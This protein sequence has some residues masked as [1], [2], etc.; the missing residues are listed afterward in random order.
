MAQKTVTTLVDD[1][2]NGPAD[3]TVSFALDGTSYEMDLSKSHAQQLRDALAP[4]LG[5]ARKS[6]GSGRRPGSR[7]RSGG[8]A[9]GGSDRQKVADIRSW[10]KSKGLKVSERGRISGA[11]LEQYE[12][13]H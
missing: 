6:S 11:V 12:A 5:A 7:G 10:A 4:Y 1:I 13:E 3:E 9:S 8:S 2:D